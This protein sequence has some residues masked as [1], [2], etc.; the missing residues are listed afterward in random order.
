MFKPEAYDRSIDCPIGDRHKSAMS[1]LTRRVQ[2]ATVGEVTSTL[3]RAERPALRKFSYAI[4][5]R[6]DVCR[7]ALAIQFP[8]LAVAT[9]KAEA[10]QFDI[11]VSWDTFKQFVCRVKTTETRQYAECLPDEWEPCLLLIIDEVP[12]LAELRKVA[13]QTHRDRR[14]YEK[15]DEA[16]SEFAGLKHLL[17]P[18]DRPCS[19]LWLEL[20]AESSLDLEKF[21]H[22]WIHGHMDKD[23]R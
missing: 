23:E 11:P 7:L 13:E 18:T 14:K 20:F 12:R 16:S 8:G 22:T 2:K 5:K 21:E 3:D 15:S 17:M 19:A 9:E 6:I 10:D 4:Y 1:A